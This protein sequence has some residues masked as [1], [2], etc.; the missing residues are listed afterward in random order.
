MTA[1][2]QVYGQYAADGAQAPDEATL[3][4]LCDRAAACWDELTVSDEALVE[5]LARRGLCDADDAGLAELVLA[6]G[7]LRGDAAAHRLVERH[8]FDVVP[9]ALAHMKLSAAMVDD[10]A[11]VV[12]E[13]LLIGGGSRPPRIGQY[14]GEGKLRSLVHV[15]AVR[16]AISALR[17]QRREIPVDGDELQDLPDPDRDPELA[18]LKHKYRAEFKASF[19]E[20]LAELSE[21]ERNLLRLHL[22]GGVTLDQLADMYSVHRATVVRWLAKAR[23]RVFSD[24]R[25]RLSSKLKMSPDEFE[26]L[27]QMIRSRL[28]V[29]ISRVLRD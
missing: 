5:L 23:Q 18:F 4:S 9:A 20:V 12:R 10:V 15:V 19:H 1:L 21:R 14:A 2:T 28:D 24:T 13:K 7:C 16:T 29:S 11:Q 17:K 8:Y 6:V 25:R 3:R 22:L 26:S 27:M